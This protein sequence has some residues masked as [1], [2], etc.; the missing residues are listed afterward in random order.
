[1]GNLC[2]K[3][4]E[5]QNSL[6]G[7]VDQVEIDAHRQLRAQG[8]LG[9]NIVHAEFDRDINE[10]YEMK[11]GIEL[12]RGISGSVKSVVHKGTGLVFACKTLDKL[13]L[14]GE[15]LEELKLEIGFLKTLDH[16]NILRLY[17][18]F[19]T[20]ETIFLIMHLCSGGELLDR[21]HSQN[22][23]R[24]TENV[25]CEYVRQILA[26]VRYCHDEGVVHRDLKLENFLLDT[27]DV[28]ASIKLIDFGLSAFF[29]DREIL[30]RSVGTPYYVAPEVLRGQYTNACDVWSL[31]VIAYML[32]SGIAPFWGRTDQEIFKKVKNGIWSFDAKIFKSVSPQAKGFIKSCLNINDRERPTAKELQ[33]HAWFKMYEEGEVEATPLPIL[34]NLL[35]FHKQE[36][37]VRISMEVIAH[38]LN[39]TKLTEL[40]DLFVQFDK[41]KSGV[42][43]ISEFKD[44]IKNH[45]HFREED[46]ETIFKGVDVENTGT[47]KYHE[48]LAATIKRQELDE[49]SIKI[50]F[51]KISN[52]NGLIN[53]SDLK[54]LLGVEGS[55][56]MVNNLLA[57]VGLPPGSDIDINK[58]RQ[59][60][61]G[62]DESGM[63]RKSYVKAPFTGKDKTI[64]QEELIKR[65]TIVISRSAP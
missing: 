10:F 58:F 12:G 30:N 63:A 38:A 65:S 64:V 50:A 32:V 33:Q 53:P 19:E 31:G 28:D 15:K 39:P 4:V 44:I 49:Q 36:G 21:L 24:Y 6:L 48:F 47:I 22:H 17:E 7:R 26:A 1:M 37:I 62:E 18:Y 29:K 60:M 5:A 46:F 16:P 52:R 41:D 20:K 2:T 59:I 34:D 51:E 27:K 61:K 55:D 54:D 3:N 45:P 56:E 11:C 40:M 9:Q 13:S 43:R 42:I 35:D 8:S 57:E 23:S 25:A 14:T